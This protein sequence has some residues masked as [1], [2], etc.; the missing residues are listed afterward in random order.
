MELY[1]G[2]DLNSNNSYVV[3][4]ETGGRRRFARRL[5]NDLAVILPE[6]TIYPA[7]ERPL[8][9]LPRRRSQLVRGCDTESRKPGMRGRSSRRQQARLR[10]PDPAS[11]A[12][13]AC[14]P[15]TGGR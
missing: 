4:L 3:V 7:A 2:L 10:T 12:K 9:A 11:G 8:R 1:C 6:G 5:P 13:G 15:C 14:A